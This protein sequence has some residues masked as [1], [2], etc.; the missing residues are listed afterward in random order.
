MPTGNLRP[1]KG[2]KNIA[3]FLV[4]DPHDKFWIRKGHPGKKL[5]IEMDT[6]GGQNMAICV[7]EMRYFMTVEFDFYIIG[8]TKNA[9]DQFFNQMKLKYQKKDIFSWSEAI[10]ILETK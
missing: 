8:H 2:S 7:V 10:E 6:L 3:S 4:E 1:R 5:T 9:C